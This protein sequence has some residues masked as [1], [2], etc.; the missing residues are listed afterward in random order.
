MPVIAERQIAE[1]DGRTRMRGDGHDSAHATPIHV[2]PAITAAIP[3][4]DQA[5]IGN[6]EK[7]DGAAASL[8]SCR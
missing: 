7:R 1:D 6:S 4:R 2:S 5:E 8:R 3:S